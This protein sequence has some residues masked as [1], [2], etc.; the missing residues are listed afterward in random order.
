MKKY[1]IEIYGPDSSHDVFKSFESDTPFLAINKG[2]L[3]NAR[4]FSDEY[5]GKIFR[6]KNTEHIIWENNGEIKHKICV[7]T[8]SVEDSIESR[9]I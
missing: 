6:V 3:I 5:K 8:N 4:V 9:F 2:D 1:C 7:F